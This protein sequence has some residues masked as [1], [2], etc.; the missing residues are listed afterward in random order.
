MVKKFTVLVI[1]LLLTVVL[2]VSCKENY[3]RDAVPTDDISS[4][5]VESNGGLAVK[6]GKYLYYINGYAGNTVDNTFG[7]VL[8]GAILRAELSED[9]TPKV[10]TNVVIV[11]KNVYS[12]VATSGLYIVGDYLYYSSPSVDK[13][14]TGTVRNGAMYLMRSKLDGTGTQVIAKF[15]DFTPVY[16]VVDGYVLYILNNELHEINLSSKKFDD[17]LVAE[18]L[19]ANYIPPHADD[20]NSFV[21][22]VF[23]LKTSEIKTETHNI[24]WFYRA[25]SDGPKQAIIGNHPSYDK[26]FLE[27]STGYT[28]ALVESMYLS[29]NKLRLI[30]T[31]TDSG[32]NTT[33]SG[34]YSFDFDETMVFDYTKEVRYTA[35][36]NITGLRFLN[37]NTLVA[38]I[39]TD[40]YLFGRDVNGRWS[41][42]FAKA[43]IPSSSTIISVDESADSIT[44]FFLSSS[45]I[46]RV[47]IIDKSNDGAFNVKYESEATEVFSASYNS[48][49]Q[50]LD[51]IGNVIYF[52]HSGI[53]DYTYYQDLSKAVSRN[54]DTMTPKQ[55]SQI[56]KEDQAAI[57]TL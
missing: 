56:T 28:L 21:N 44:F 19:T 29:S 22:T 8:K 48:T 37:D 9:G 46:Y 40:I 16:K 55:L 57:L 53:K 6:K 41:K 20:E 5:L 24:I 18:E 35:G 54:A 10:N 51:K 26:S 42:A 23:Y 50:Q 52:W 11:P 1:C 2:L 30:Y 33:S 7:S 45:K 13:D 34:T 14:K 39:G 17:K 27:I 3:K 32:V 36:N 43:L 25:G 15:D 47:K 31:K 49:W 12:S 38:S 4:A